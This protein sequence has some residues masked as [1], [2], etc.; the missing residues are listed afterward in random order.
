M[1]FGIVGPVYPYRGGIAHFNGHLAND[2]QKA[3]HDVKVFSFK[4]QYPAWL[5]PGESDQDGSADPLHTQAAF[6]LDPFLPWELTK[7][8]DE[9]CSWQPDLVLITWWTTFWWLAFSVLVSILNYRKVKTAFLIHNIFPH[10][11]RWW[12]QMVTRFALR[13]MKRFLGQSDSQR[14]RLLVLNRMPSFASVRIPFTTCS[15]SRRSAKLKPGGVGF[16]HKPLYASVLWNCPP[17]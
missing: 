11:F 4:R 17:L 2:S 1:R 10:E 9:I 15:F 7:C 5:Y 12:D 3:G 13:R 6:L 8:A 16:A 14:D